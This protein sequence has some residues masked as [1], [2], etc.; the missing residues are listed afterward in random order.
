MPGKSPTLRD[1]AR[2]L[3]VSMTT[4]S[5]ALRETG[6]VS[7]T[8]RARVREVAKAIGYTPNRAAQELR[9]RTS[10]TVGLYIP[11]RV[12]A[13]EFYMPF[14]MALADELGRGH[15][16]LTVIA[17]AESQT[18]A[19][20]WDDFAAVIVIDARISDAP[21]SANLESHVPLFTAGRIQGIS[22]S[23]V[24]AV[25]ELDYRTMLRSAL[26]RLHKERLIEHPIFLAFEAA[27]DYSWSHQLL[28]EY[29][30]WWQ[31]K[32]LLANYWTVSAK[33]DQWPTPAMLAEWSGAETRYDVIIFGGPLLAL[34][35]RSQDGFDALLSKDGHRSI[36][37]TTSEVES[38]LVKSDIILDIRARKFGESIGN[39]C[40]NYLTGGDYP[41][42]QFIEPSIITDSK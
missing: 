22:S 29:H 31:R 21:L 13:Q 32:Q 23:R 16:D 17:D 9:N 7:P 10:R 19:S 30:D 11:R 4:A 35:T 2:H 5:D 28:S 26:D 14:T 8:T 36:V 1:L 6:R 18:D 12:M 20:S 27:Y 25:V 40:L 38:R 41:E 42:H 24:A 33:P 34:V 39:I 37:L 15:L 3:G